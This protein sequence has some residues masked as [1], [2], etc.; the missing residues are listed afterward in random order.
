MMFASRNVLSNGWRIEYS[1]VMPIL[2]I[3]VCF[4]LALKRSVITSTFCF[5]R[6]S[7]FSEPTIFTATKFT[8][9]CR[10]QLGIFL[11]FVLA[12]TFDVTLTLCDGNAMTVNACVASGKRLGTYHT[13]CVEPVVLKLSYTATITISILGIV[14]KFWPAPLCQ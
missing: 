3:F 14:L 5:L 4:L 7:F 6:K 11:V 2:Q 13:S 12:S 8:D 1:Y 10:K 9:F